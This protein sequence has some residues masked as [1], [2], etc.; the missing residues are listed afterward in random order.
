MDGV[1]LKYSMLKILIVCEAVLCERSG[2]LQIR[3]VLWF[4]EKYLHI[5]QIRR[6]LWLAMLLVFII[7]QPCVELAQNW[8][9]AVAVLS[10]HACLGFI[11]SH[12]FFKQPKNLFSHRQN[13]PHFFVGSEQPHIPQFRKRI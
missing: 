12:H 13:L 1:F 9:E 8:G 5:L 3:R 4:R 2:K 11:F 7:I 6:V 10:I